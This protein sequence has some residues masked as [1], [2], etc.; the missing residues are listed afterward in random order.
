MI[1][2]HVIH[3]TVYVQGYFKRDTEDSL[4]MCNPSVKSHDS[5]RP[6]IAFQTS[7]GKV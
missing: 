5:F 3:C 1:K 4:K 7:M 6:L 2:V